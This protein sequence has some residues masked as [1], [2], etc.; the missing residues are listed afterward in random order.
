M[1]SHAVLAFDWHSLSP[2]SIIVDVGGGLATSAIPIAMNVPH[3]K[4]VVQDLL[5][6]VEQG[7]KV[8]FLF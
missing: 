5:S 8:C 2:G 6:V 4:V 1:S 7:R 3:V